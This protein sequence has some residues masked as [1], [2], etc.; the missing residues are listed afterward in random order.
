[1]LKLKNKI[2]NRLKRRMEMTEGR[3]REFKERT[4]ELSEQ[5]R[6][7]CFLQ[8]EPIHWCDARVESEGLSV[9]LVDGGY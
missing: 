5:Q 7:K 8:N 1:M 3:V 2:T 4:M 9:D 6:E